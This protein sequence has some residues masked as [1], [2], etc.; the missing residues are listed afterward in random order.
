MSLGGGNYITQNKVLPGS[1][2][3]FASAARASAVLSERGFAAIPLEL[4]WGKDD[5]VFTVEAADF[6]SNSLKLFGYDY[7]D[8]KLKDIRELFRNVKTL[9]CYRLNSGVKAATVSDNLTVTAKNSGIRG[10]DI[11]IVITT[12]VDDPTLFE[13]STIVGATKVE[14]Q[15]ARTVEEL[16]AND[17]VTFSGIGDLSV[18]AG[19][20]LIGGT[21]K[22][23]VEGADYQLFL[24][25]IEAYSFNAIGCPSTT[26]SVID[27]FVQFT[28]RMR[29]T[30]GIKFQTVVYRTAADYEGIISVENTVLDA[31]VNGASLIYWVTG[32][33]AAC[34]INR[35]NANKKYDGEYTID[36]NY[37][38]SQLEQGIKTGKFMFHKVGSEARVLDDVNSFVTV[39]PEKNEDF[40]S[41][42]V[43]R[44]LDQ[45][46][47]DIALLFNSKYLG[48]V[49][50]NASG[51]TAFWNEL[52]TYNKEMVRTQAIE[53][54]K[55][56]DVVVE[57]GADKKSVVVSNPVT[58]L[59]AMTKLY[60]TVIVQ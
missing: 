39:T 11:R 19:M 60:M 51:R 32:A 58:P 12:N 36:V 16:I 30:S 4:D 13:V 1:Y 34:A 29:D 25:K 35:S 53:D 26:A 9:Y 24:D 31:G 45:F 38:Q 21:N 52:V 48:K 10:N 22:A 57:Q 55:A 47:N 6:Q 46:A 28:K 41:N 2:I 3:N 56:S 20:N 7:A 59:N 27:L 40:S 42:Q 49:Q 33:N 43:I 50:N 54:F 15:L 8:P 44:V 18:S 37:K 23:S 17:F 5:A 14:T